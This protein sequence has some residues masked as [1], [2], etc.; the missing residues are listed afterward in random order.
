L[1]FNLRKC[2][3][4]LTQEIHVSGKYDIMRSSFLAN[5]NQKRQKAEMEKIF[6]GIGN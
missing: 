2:P 3:S 6:H 5:G 4:A 1:T